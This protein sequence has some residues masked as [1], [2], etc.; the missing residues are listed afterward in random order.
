MMETRKRTVMIAALVILAAGLAAGLVLAQDSE[1]AATVGAIASEDVS[2][3]GRVAA[4]LGI[5]ESALSE[6]IELARVQEIDAAVA[7]G[8]LTEEQAAEM[9]ARIEARGA[10]Q[11]VIDEAISSG[12]LTEEQAELLQLRGLRGGMMGAMQG[13]RERAAELRGMLEDE[14][15]ALR[16][17]GC[18]PFG[19]TL[20]TPRGVFRGRICGRP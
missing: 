3:L 1:E 6:A 7:G 12:R 10:L 19:F 17:S 2:F 11:D 4:N 9:K 20:R 18:G 16:D 14:S 13:L 5:S 15:G 8:L